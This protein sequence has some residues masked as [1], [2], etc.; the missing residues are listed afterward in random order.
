MISSSEVIIDSKILWENY[1]EYTKMFSE[2]I[3]SH[4]LKYNDDYNKKET[5]DK[6]KAFVEDLLKNDISYNNFKILCTEFFRRS[7]R[8]TNAEER[9][10]I[11]RITRILNIHAEMILNTTFSRLIYIIWTNKRNS[12]GIK[13]N[14]SFDAYTLFTKTTPIDTNIEAATISAFA[15][16]LEFKDKVIIP[17][18]I[19]DIDLG[20]IFSIIAFNGMYMANNV[21]VIYNEKGRFNFIKNLT[22][23]ITE[24]DELELQKFLEKERENHINVWNEFVKTII[25]RDYDKGCAILKDNIFIK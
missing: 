21:D 10:F 8:Y 4:D 1:N 16:I 25:D 6:E 13:D 22:E 20:T 2:S 14:K 11:Y 24:K 7:I 3:F 9:N 17:N 15:M 19:D 12:N 23:K 18:N 5:Y